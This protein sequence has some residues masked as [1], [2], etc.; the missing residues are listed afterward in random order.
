MVNLSTARM[1][2]AP[3]IRG[4][5]RCC[6]HGDNEQPGHNHS[7]H[8]QRIGDLHFI[9]PF[10]DFISRFFPGHTL[11]HFHDPKI[12]NAPPPTVF[13]VTKER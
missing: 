3:G 5:T 1:I 8:F 7:V 13:S 11:V 4:V 6:P 2:L 9:L 10:V 12:Q